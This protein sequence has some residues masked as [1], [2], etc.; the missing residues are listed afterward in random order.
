VALVTPF[1]SL[2]TSLARTA[3]CTCCRRAVNSSTYPLSDGHRVRGEACGA[4]CTVR[5]WLDDYTLHLCHQPLTRIETRALLE[6]YRTIPHFYHRN[7][8]LVLGGTRYLLP[9]LRLIFSPRHQP[10]AEQGV[11]TLLALPDAQLVALG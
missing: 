7:R 9:T 1:H 2:S 8:K 10:A 3:D 4:H 6:C 5:L 11:L